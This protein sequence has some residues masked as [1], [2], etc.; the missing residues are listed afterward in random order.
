MAKAQIACACVDVDPDAFAGRYTLQPI[1][2]KHTC[3]P[4]I[5]TTL[6]WQ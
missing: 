2:M 5:E 1:T 3:K 4:R 6:P